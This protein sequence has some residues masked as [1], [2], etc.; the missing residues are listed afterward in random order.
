MAHSIIITIIVET[1]KV[2]EG[3]NELFLCT[4]INRVYV[5]LYLSLSE[6]FLIY[7]QFLIILLYGFQENAY[8]CHSVKRDVK[9]F[10]FTKE[11]IVPAISFRKHLICAVFLKICSSNHCFFFTD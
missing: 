5:S 11:L 1:F 2:E 9:L 4:G 10:P 7:F 3:S 8:F 6:T